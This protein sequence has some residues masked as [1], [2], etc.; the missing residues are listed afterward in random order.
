ML[1]LDTCR[2]S[3]GYGI[4]PDTDSVGI[5]PALRLDSPQTTA[6]GTTP[7]VRGDAIVGGGPI[8]S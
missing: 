2:V 1:R 4:L 3:A 8:P 5:L 7:V 6:Q